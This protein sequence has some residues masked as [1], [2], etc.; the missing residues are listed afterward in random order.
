M[1]FIGSLRSI[2]VIV[3]FCLLVPN[4]AYASEIR[5]AFSGDVFQ[6]NVLVSFAKS[7]YS[8]GE[9]ILAHFVFTDA[10]TGQRPRGSSL[11]ARI[12]GSGPFTQIFAIAD[13]SDTADIT[14]PV[15]GGEVPKVIQLNGTVGGWFDISSYDV[16]RFDSQNYTFELPLDSSAPSDSTPSSPEVSGSCKVGAPS[17]LTL[18]SRSPSGVRLFYYAMFEGET[19]PTRVPL[20][21]FLDSGVAASFTR[22]APSDGLYVLY[23]RAVTESGLASDWTKA[24]VPCGDTCVFCVNDGSIAR[25]T[26]DARPS[27]IRRG[28]TTKLSWSLANVQSCSMAGTNGDFWGWDVVKVAQSLSTSEINASTKFTLSCLDM[29]GKTVTASKDVSIV[30]IWTEQ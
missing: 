14:L 2:A 28:G 12:N 1:G 15:S 11:Q 24:N 16:S 4:G 7:V 3:V 8:A 9:S 26:L 21:G 27:L 23:A 10:V 29:T 30:P 5:E 25:I 17:T 13:P 6:A 18:M 19:T 22:T 20:S